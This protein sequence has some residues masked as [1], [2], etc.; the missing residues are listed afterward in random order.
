MAEANKVVI[1]VD[2]ALRSTEQTK[3]TLGTRNLSWDLDA[4]LDGHA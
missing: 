3:E 1:W 2:E 4:R